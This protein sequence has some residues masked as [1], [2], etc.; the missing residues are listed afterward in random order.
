M[1]AR[2]KPKTGRALVVGSRVYGEGIDRRGLYRKAVG[3]DM[4]VGLGVD[5]VHDLEEPLS[6]AAGTF[7]HVDCCSVLEHVRRPWLMAQNIERL[8]APRG[9]LLVC[10]PFVWRYH[11]YPGDYWRFTPEAFEVLF[12]A[13]EWREVLL[14][15][16]GEIVE[17]APAF[18]EDN[19]ARWLGRTEVAG[20]GVK[21]ASIS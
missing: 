12:P 2:H 9:T 4:Q 21:C 16:N 3:L 14:F 17:R 15:A 18:N 6:T 20:F 13:I 5:L 7:D 8:L 11:A 1:L 10:A 19:G